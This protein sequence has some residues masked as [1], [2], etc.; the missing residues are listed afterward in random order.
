M[1]PRNSAG[2]RNSRVSFPRLYLASGVTTLRTTAP[3][4]FMSEGSGSGVD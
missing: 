4:V 3:S 1:V 2:V